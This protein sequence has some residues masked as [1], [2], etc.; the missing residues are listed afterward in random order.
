MTV[1]RTETELPWFGQEFFEQALT[2]AVLDADAYRQARER[3]LRATRDNGIDAVMRQHSLHALVAPTYGPAWLRDLVNG[4]LPTTLADTCVVAGGRRAFLTF[5]SPGQ[6]NFQL[7]AAAQDTAIDVQGFANCNLPTEA[8]SPVATPP[9][10]AT[11]VVPESV[12]LPGLV[13]IVSVMASVKLDTVLPTESCAATCTAGSVT[14]AVVVM[15]C[16]VNP[17]WVTAAVTISNGALVT[18]VNPSAVA[19]SV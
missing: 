15:G 2:D 6:I 1:T 16:T 17:S 5:V 13:P 9:T 19:A 18:P 11:V 14:P 4:D 8:R 3:G 10:A 12:P 7:P